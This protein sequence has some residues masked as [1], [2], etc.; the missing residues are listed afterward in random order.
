VSGSED[1]A[2]EISRSHEVGLGDNALQVDTDAK[3]KLMAKLSFLY[4]YYRTPVLPSEANH[5]MGTNDT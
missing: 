2:T 3:N 4:T 5:G 1:G